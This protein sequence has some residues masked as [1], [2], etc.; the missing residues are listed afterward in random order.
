MKNIYCDISATTPLSVDVAEYMHQIQMNV[1]GN[2]SS[3]HRFGQESKAILEKSRRQISTALNCSPGEIYF[4]G[5]GSESNNMALQALL[6]P[7]DHVVSS[8]YEH[9]A[10]L[11]TLDYLESNDISVSRIKPDANGIV[12]CEAVEAAIKENTRLVSIMFVNNEVGTINPVERISRCCRDSNILFHTDAVQAFGKIPIDMAELPVDLLSMSAHKLYGPKGV[13]A[14]FIRNGTGINPIL[15]GGGQEKNL[16]PGTE[17]IPGIAAFGLAAE[18]SQQNLTDTAHQIKNLTD[19]FLDLLKKSG[20]DFSQNGKITIPGVLNLTFPNVDA[21]TLV[22]SLDMAGVAVSAGS[23]C[24]AGTVKVSGTLIEM[25]LN[26]KAAA[27]SIRISF[28]KYHT[29]EDI[30]FVA[31]KICDIISKR[32]GING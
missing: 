2:P 1:F 11:K 17:N 7:G 4:T 25:G 13:G 14:L 8:S 12:T 30:E 3:I 18:L 20:L 5:C 23:A 15:F 26:R 32:Q 22:M 10:I 21:Q 29:I 24:S 6:K 27:S 19:Q 9:P 31:G 28:G 16:R